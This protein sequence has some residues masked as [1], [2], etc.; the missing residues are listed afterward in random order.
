MKK[1]ELAVDI[2]GLGSGFP[3]EVHS[4]NPTRYKTHT[5][6]KGIDLYFN[7]KQVDLLIQQGIIREVQE[8]IFT[9]EDVIEMLADCQIIRTVNTKWYD[10][11]AGQHTEYVDAETLVSEKKK[12]KGNEQNS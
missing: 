7:E 9:E 1:Y 12:E 6:C 11:T 5:N 8:P 4:Y 10:S 2:G 3:I